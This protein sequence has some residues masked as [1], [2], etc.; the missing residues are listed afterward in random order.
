MLHGT[1]PTDDRLQALPQ[2]M[3]THIILQL[4]YALQLKLR[5]IAK[6]WKN[7]IESNS[8]LPL[9]NRAVVESAL[10]YTSSKSANFEEI[11]IQALNQNYASLHLSPTSL[12][13]LVMKFQSKNG[14]VNEEG[15]F[16]YYPPA[17]EITIPVDKVFLLAL[18]KGHLT[19]QYDSFVSRDE[20]H[21]FITH[22]MALPN[23]PNHPRW[24][25]LNKQSKASLQRLKESLGRYTDPAYRSLSQEVDAA[26]LARESGLEANN[27]LQRSK[28][29]LD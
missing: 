8:A 4:P 18:K 10:N 14:Y 5:V 24:K 1:S 11:N 13:S 3:L 6:Y 25:F 12:D 19:E 26:L 28:K 29:F 9:L 16:E 7:S 22:Y 15:I 20:R 21:H 27:P 2:E 23:H 17:P